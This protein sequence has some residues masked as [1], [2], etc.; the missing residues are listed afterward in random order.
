MEVC[1]ALGTGRRP[2]LAK[3][4]S[5]RVGHRDSHSDGNRV[6][7]GTAALSSDQG[8]LAYAC[9][10]ERSTT[11]HRER[12]RERKR[13]RERERASERES[14]HTNTHTQILAL[15]SVYTH[16]DSVRVSSENTNPYAHTCTHTGRQRDHAARGARARR[17]RVSAQGVGISTMRRR[18]DLAVR[19]GPQRLPRRGRPHGQQPECQVPPRG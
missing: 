17:R 18:H 4:G 10:N 3:R 12:K 15:L 1:R 14:T 16:T 6:E 8:D 13:E 7:R 19:G 9:I 2:P 11:L 5:G